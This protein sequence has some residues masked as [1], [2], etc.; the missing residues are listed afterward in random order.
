[1]SVDRAP[2][3]QAPPAPTG[4]AEPEDPLRMAQL[5]KRVHVSA[6][7]KRDSR[8][9][10][11]RGE[12][13]VQTGRH[14]PE[15][16]APKSAA[17][18]QGVEDATLFVVQGVLPR[19]VG[20][21]N[22]LFA[23]SP[24]LDTTGF[25]K[26]SALAPAAPSPTGR[27]RPAV[28]G[29]AEPKLSVAQVRAILPEELA[30]G[31]AD[32]RRTAEARVGEL[33]EKLMQRGGGGAQ[34]LDE[35][36]RAYATTARGFVEDA[37]A[38][39]GQGAAAAWT[40][41]TAMKT[42]DARAMQ[43]AGGGDM[44]L[45]QA[46]GFELGSL[47]HQLAREAAAASTPGGRVRGTIRAAARRLADRDRLKAQLTPLVAPRVQAALQT[48]TTGFAAAG[49]GPVPVGGSDITGDVLAD[50]RDRFGVHLDQT[51]TDAT[52]AKAMGKLAAVFDRAAPEAGDSA[53]LS[54]KIKVPIYMGTYV[55]IG[56][57]A[58]VHRGLRGAVNAA[59]D[60]PTPDR[61]WIEARGDIDLEAGWEAVG[62]DVAA[63]G[64]V[65][66]RAGAKTP[67]KVADA[68]SYGMYRKFGK[69]DAFAR[70]WAGDGLRAED[71]PGKRDRAEMWAAG[72]EEE[73]FGD[74]AAAFVDTGWK[75]GAR[76][77]VGAAGA[78]FEGKVGFTKFRRWNQAALKT[79][80]ETPGTPDAE[81]P[82]GLGAAV[83]Q[84]TGAA[85]NA[86]IRDAIDRKDGGQYILPSKKVLSIALKASLPQIGGVGVSFKGVMA[87]F[88]GDKG[89]KGRVFNPWDA[90]IEA[91]VAFGPIV[92]AGSL[93]KVIESIGHTVGATMGK[94][95][96]L[97]GGGEQAH[98]AQGAAP[99]LQGAV[100]SD[101]ALTDID[102]AVK[103]R[104]A[105]AVHDVAHHANAR[106]ANPDTA[107]NGGLDALGAKIP[108]AKPT[109]QGDK[110]N[111]DSG[112]EKFSAAGV[113]DMASKLR[114]ELLFARPPGPATADE[115]PPI[116]LSLM[117]STLS[118]LGLNVGL[119][120]AS[121]ARGARI[122]LLGPF[123]I[124]KGKTKPPTGGA[125]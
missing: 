100:G 67:Q 123:D 31:A 23:Y 122:A 13:G 16:K 22:Y 9:H 108:D 61:N 52:P 41:F 62:L 76:A 43:A 73:V 1:M 33:F 5:E 11:A 98:A 113:L 90:Q 32:V 71:G 99:A 63:G 29:G 83:A 115:H 104:A 7:T 102:R 79:A 24:K 72:K 40:D 45:A 3:V 85:R 119:L 69:Y 26:E 60:V 50:A 25:M 17:D 38:G 81:Q 80:L 66:L 74:D 107:P 97:G 94:V 15:V 82:F 121:Y 101:P 30:M 65:M 109:W 105:H 19:Q 84:G 116:K 117:V 44:V 95:E 111:V 91:D 20:E 49:T 37:R 68:L 10:P 6:S 75:V 47:A 89:T 124:R 59:G 54:V 118:N 70:V 27:P 86:Q 8:L 112:L 92:A 28:G 77:K 64:G 2:P 48:P 96:Q 51:I 36:K 120:K 103:S 106:T 53:K 88:P 58:E 4:E 87:K 55:Q 39:G 78:T 114:F 34:K 57:S 110:P 12:E 42:F 35:L 14:G 93:L 21:K 46:D 125:R 56:V 18:A